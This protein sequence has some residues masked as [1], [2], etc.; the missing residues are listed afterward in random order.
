MD[1]GWVKLHRRMVEKAFYKRSAYVHLWVHLLL[2]ANHKT[3][4][5]MWN[6]RIIMVKEGQLVTGRKEL[7]KE[8]GI[9]ETTI[10]RILGFLEN[11][12]QIGQQKTTKYRL[13]TIVNWESFQNGSD[14]K[15]TTNGQQTDT[16]KNDKNVKKNKNNTQSSDEDGK[17]VNQIIDLF[18]DV[19]PSYER[20]FSNKTQRAAVSRLVKK[21]G[22]DKV[23]GMVLSLESVITQKFAPRITTPIELERDLGKLVAFWKQNKPV[24]GKLIL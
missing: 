9:P 2:S 23:S 12:G 1:N 4:E 11:D 16:N 8:T 6:D 3:K 14:N 21:W 22:F 20:L 17:E 5:F 13:I 7:S 19:N 15:R 24:K 10:E 18:K